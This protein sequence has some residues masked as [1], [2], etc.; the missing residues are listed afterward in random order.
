MFQSSGD[1][2]PL[3]SAERG[4]VVALARLEKPLPASLRFAASRRLAVERDLA[5]ALPRG[6]TASVRSEVPPGLSAIHPSWIRYVLAREALPLAAALQECLRQAGVQGGEG[7]WNDISPAPLPR[8]FLG[9]ILWLL[10]GRLSDPDPDQTTFPADRPLDEGSAGARSVLWHRLPGSVLWRALCE[11]GACEV[12]RSLRGAEPVM[13]ARAM[14]TVGVPWAQVIARTAS[15]AFDAPARDRSR[16]AVAR[17]SAMAGRDDVPLEGAGRPGAEVRL[18]FVG[19]SAA[20]S[21]LSA[22]GPEALRTIAL[23]LPA[24]VGRFLLDGGPT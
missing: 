11:R 6:K 8:A 14:A 23:R 5:L 4:V 22:A 12:G 13:R 17:A 24:V 18:A 10:F 3:T 20:R 9:D 21:E 16:L 2:P 1:D 19:L 15:E 7:P